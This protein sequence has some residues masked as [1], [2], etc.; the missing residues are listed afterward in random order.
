VVVA[1]K[2]R[3][4]HKKLARKGPPIHRRRLAQTLNNLGNFYQETLAFAEARA[5]F[6]EVREIQ[7]GLARAD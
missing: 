4:I 3:D 6:E 7:Q 1:E 2:A 5:A